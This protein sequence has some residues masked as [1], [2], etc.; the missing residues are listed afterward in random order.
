RLYR[1]WDAAVI[2]M[3]AMPEARLA[4]EAEICYVTIA[5]VTD[6][7]VWHESEAAVTV[8]MVVANLRRNAETARTLI[9]TMARTGLPARACPC[10]SALA[11]AII[12]DRT[13]I[14]PEIRARLGIIGARY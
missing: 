7:D 6:Y 2:G 13:A 14:S 8:E 11:D 4:R 10:E 12:T 5:M 3:T 1:S 9:Q